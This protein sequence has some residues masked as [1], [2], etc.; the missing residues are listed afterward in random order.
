MKGKDVRNNCKGS[1]RSQ[2]YGWERGTREL[3]GEVR[4]GGEGI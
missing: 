2:G 4:C 3:E 1:A